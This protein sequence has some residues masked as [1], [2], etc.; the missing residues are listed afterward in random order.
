MIKQ[1]F[2]G[3]RTIADQVNITNT[4]VEE[5]CA[6][7]F[8]STRN[9][10]ETSFTYLNNDCNNMYSVLIKAGTS[11]KMKRHQMRNE[12][13]CLA[14]MVCIPDKRLSVKPQKDLSGG[15]WNARPKVSWVWSLGHH[16][17]SANKAFV[18]QEQLVRL[19]F[20]LS[21]QPSQHQSLTHELNK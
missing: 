7:S 18:G 15:L 16:G 9:V 4:A 11:A 5:L 1:S 3:A 14:L 17:W 6:S 10:V 8:T 12:E 19:E 13:R 20:G 2:L 21:K